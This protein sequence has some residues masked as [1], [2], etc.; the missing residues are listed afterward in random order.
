MM[1]RYL[2]LVL[3]L[4]APLLAASCGGDGS[5]TAPTPAAPTPAPAPT[6]TPIVASATA[7][8]SV[9]F[10]ATWS[11]GTHPEDFP[12]DPHFS[13]LVGATHSARV[14]F[15]EP[16]ALATLGI[17]AMAEMGRTTP[18]ANEIRPAIDQATAQYLLLGGGINPSPGATAFDFDISRDFPLVT[19]VTMVAPSPDWFAGVH[20]MSLIENG[21]WVRERVVTLFAYDAGT[22]SGAS[23]ESADRDTQP[24]E[25]IQRIAGFPLAVNGAVAPVGAYTFR[26]IDN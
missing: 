16:G 15:W 7:R 5:P 3:A 1:R 9:T 11:R 21:D 25:P 20:D 22:D 26:R 10:Q 17:E 13:P 8:Y 24:R 2:I 14:R 19:L 6:P 23:Y 4:G 12:G 18:L